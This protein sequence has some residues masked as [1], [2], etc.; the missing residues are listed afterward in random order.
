MAAINTS[1]ESQ[2]PAEAIHLLKWEVRSG[3]YGPKVPV[4]DRQMAVRA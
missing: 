2:Q 1:P 3:L 4:E